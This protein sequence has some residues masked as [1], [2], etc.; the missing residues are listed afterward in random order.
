MK[1]SVFGILPFLFFKQCY[2]LAN[3]SFKVEIKSCS[4]LVKSLNVPYKIFIPRAE[5]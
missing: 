4:D 2:M 5:I 3:F 1:T